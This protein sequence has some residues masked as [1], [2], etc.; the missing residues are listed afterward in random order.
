L[1]WIAM[2]DTCIAKH[3]AAQYIV[4]ASLGKTRLGSFLRQTTAVGFTSHS[5]ALYFPSARARHSGSFS[6]EM[7]SNCGRVF[8]VPTACLTATDDSR[9]VRACFA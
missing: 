4:H 7:L 1:I 5:C 6:M 3:S 8:A 2:T 9:T